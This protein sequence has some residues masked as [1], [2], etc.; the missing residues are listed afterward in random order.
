MV[1]PYPYF[2]TRTHPFELVGTQLGEPWNVRRIYRRGAGIEAMYTQGGPPMLIATL[3]NDQDAQDWL[4]ELAI[5]LIAD[6]LQR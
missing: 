1:T 4:D 5:R 2:W 6:A 3:E